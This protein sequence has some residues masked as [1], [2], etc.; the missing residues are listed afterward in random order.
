MCS[1]CMGHISVASHTAAH[2]D[3]LQST[4]RE[5]TS[6]GGGTWLISALVQQSSACLSTRCDWQKVYQDGEGRNVKSGGV[7]EHPNVKSVQTRPLSVLLVVVPAAGS[8]T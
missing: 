2:P 1:N 4:P 3:C 7:S 8:S 6:P 5:F